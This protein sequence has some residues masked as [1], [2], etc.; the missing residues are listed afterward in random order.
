MAGGE[1]GGPAPSLEQA[2]G[3]LRREDFLGPGSTGPNESN[4]P[5]PAEVPRPPQPYEDMLGGTR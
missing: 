4:V 1:C 5:A 2:F 3:E